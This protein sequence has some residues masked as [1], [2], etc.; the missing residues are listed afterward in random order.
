MTDPPRWSKNSGYNTQRSRAAES[1]DTS[2]TAPSGPPVSLSLHFKLFISVVMRL[3]SSHPY[4]EPPADDVLVLSSPPLF[5]LAHLG[6]GRVRRVL[7]D[8]ASRYALEEHCLVDRQCL[9]QDTKKKKRIR[10]RDRA[11]RGRAGG[12]SDTE[13]IMSRALFVRHM[14]GL[15][16]RFNTAEFVVLVSTILP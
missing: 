5:A 6:E 13:A 7:S 8:L 4:D 12:R 16:L 9:F 14:F 11:G 15:L 3:V 1:T 2:K 10:A